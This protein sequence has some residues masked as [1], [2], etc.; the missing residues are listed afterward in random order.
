[1][2]YLHAQITWAQVLPTPYR[3]LYMEQLEEK[4]S[5]KHKHANHNKQMQ[6]WVKVHALPMWESWGGL[7][8]TSFPNTYDPR[9]LGLAKMGLERWIRP[10]DEDVKTQ[11]K[12]DDWRRWG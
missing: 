4:C 3:D 7:W 6:R 9:W 10:E 8:G 2:I 1:M 5:N 12:E 11:S